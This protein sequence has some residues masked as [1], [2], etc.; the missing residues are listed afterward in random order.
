MVFIK[1]LEDSDE[2]LNKKTISRI[3]LMDILKIIFEDFITTLRTDPVL[4]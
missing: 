4:I 3:T 1:E 2:I